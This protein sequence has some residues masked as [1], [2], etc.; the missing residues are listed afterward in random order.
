M[1]ICMCVNVRVCAHV[2]TS[3]R[4]TPVNVLAN[5]IHIQWSTYICSLTNK[6]IFCFGV[7][8]FKNVLFLMQ[9][10]SDIL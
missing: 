8:V 10:K 3:Y 6:S 7:L 2:Y 1:H 4:K 5:P 9:L